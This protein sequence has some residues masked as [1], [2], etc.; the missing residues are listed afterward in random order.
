MEEKLKKSI[1]S[2]NLDKKQLEEAILEEKDSKNL[3]EFKKDL[4]KVI[5]ELKEKENKLNLLENE[6]QVEITINTLKQRKSEY[7][8]E[9]ENT[10]D[11]RIKNE[12]LIDL[13]KID[14]E[15]NSNEK[16]YKDLR[17]AL[18]Q[19]YDESKSEYGSNWSKGWEDTEKEEGTESAHYGPQQEDNF[20]SP[21]VIDQKE[22]EK[23]TSINKDSVEFSPATVNKNLPIRSFW[24]IYNDTKTEHCGTIGRMIY[25]MAHMNILPRN[26]DTVH[27]LLSIV[28]I[29]GK[30]VI[31][32]LAFIANKI[33][34]TDRKMQIFRDNLNSL[35]D[36]EFKVLTESADKI[37]DEN[38]KA[39][40]DV[41]YLSP[42]FMKQHK[43]DNLYLDAVREKMAEKSYE[44]VNKCNEKIKEAEQRI[45]ELSNKKD[46]TLEEIEEIKECNQSIID[47]KKMAEKSSDELKLFETGAKEKS[48]AFRNISGWIAGKFNPDTR[49]ED[50]KMAELA[51]KRRGEA[52][53]G[54]SI[55]T[56]KTSKEMRD[57]EK[58]QT[59]ILGREHGILGNIRNRIDIGKYSVESPVEMMDK[60]Q[61]TKGRLLFTNIA[62]GVA[63]A[64]FVEHIK[65]QMRVDKAV[66]D[67]NASV[68]KTNEYDSNLKS[69]NGTVNNGI[70]KELIERA[71]QDVTA[72]KVAGGKGIGEY[73]NLDRNG[74]EGWSKGLGTEQYKQ[75]D[76][77]LHS[78]NPQDLGEAV[79]FYDAAKSNA[80]NWQTT[81]ANAHPQFDYSPYLASLGKSDSQAVV[82]LF[83]K[84]DKLDASQI[85]GTVKAAMQESMPNVDLSDG[86]LWAL[87]GAI[88]AKYAQVVGKERQNVS[89]K[90]NEPKEEVEEE[91]VEQETEKEE[92]PK[93]IEG[94]EQKL[95]VDKEL[96]KSEN[97]NDND[98]KENEVEEKKEEEKLNNQVEEIRNLGNKEVE[99]KIEDIKNANKDNE[100]ER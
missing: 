50:N 31:K 2:L 74:M 11:Q 41:D 49:E 100:N 87:I 55:D 22:T 88:G 1:E 96:E 43:T 19:E 53:L 33:N 37:N 57:F 77:W 27:Q 70:D 42:N 65:N 38:I 95:L 52:N 67:H 93:T 45:E 59:N 68:N 17:I 80:M 92:E 75:Y 81:Y 3:D 48:S 25:Q 73:S 91:K 83:E 98:E 34:G 97:D 40:Y 12:I 39:A 76:Q 54:K 9:L 63:V 94:E 10:N 71:K 5:N 66:A 82:E 36:E 79:K 7:L 99:Q 62:I 32:P 13:E 84:L 47:N 78:Q 89:N 86:A 56:T 46:I 15:L 72:T 51:R 16:K 58:E 29:P 14:E 20:Q 23:S 64:N 90:I 35:S 26:E 24:E 61:Q 18:N 30:L 4:E 85:T 8:K 6:K 60:G 28:T 21:A 69:E 44:F